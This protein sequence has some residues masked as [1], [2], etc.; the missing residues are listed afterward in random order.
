MA[1]DTSLVGIYLQD[2]FA[3]ST[4]ALELVERARR[5]NEGTELEEVLAR[6]ARE[7]R[8]ERETL[9]AIMHA[10]GTRPSGLKNRAAWAA[11]KVGRLKLNGRLRGY[12]PL[13]RLVELEA[14]V[15]G[16][17]GKRSLWTSLEVLADP[18]LAG[19]DFPRLTEQAEAQLAAVEEQRRRAAA[20]LT[21][22]P[23]R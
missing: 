4:G 7:L 15:A 19:F 1:T 3:G 21:S 20:A 16:I 14:L 17:T 12:S 9:L 23:A 5:E 18:R 22:P 8:E 13:S 2:H 10:L 11:E 6:L